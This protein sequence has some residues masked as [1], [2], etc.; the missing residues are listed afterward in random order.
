MAN[1]VYKRATKRKR[2]YFHPRQKKSCI[3]LRCETNVV[4]FHKKIDK[5][6]KKIKIK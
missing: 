2:M 4:K 3:Y 1:F 6:A 5:S